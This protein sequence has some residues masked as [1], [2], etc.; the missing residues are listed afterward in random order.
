MTG[1]TAEPW[2]AVLGR[3]GD[4]AVVVTDAAGKVYF[5]TTWTC[6]RSKP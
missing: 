2:A 5:D 3:R 4:D 6:V 1:P